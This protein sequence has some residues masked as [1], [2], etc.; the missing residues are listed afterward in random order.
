[1][2]SLTT[3]ASFVVTGS[4]YMKLLSPAMPKAL[5]FKYLDLWL[6]HT[7]SSASNN[8]NLE[9]PIEKNVNVKGTQ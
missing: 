3:P 5:N 4:L 8:C 1:M 6:K 9:F 2:V 7:T